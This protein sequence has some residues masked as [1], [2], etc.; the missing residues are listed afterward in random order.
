MIFASLQVVGSHLEHHV[1][2]ARFIAPAKELA[3]AGTY[4][5]GTCTEAIFDLWHWPVKRIKS[6]G[7]AVCIPSDGIPMAS[8]VSEA[9]ASLYR[10]KKAGRNRS[11]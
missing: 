3:D 9:D 5:E 6:L 11:A 7:V 4:D 1:K 10:A 2:G 8:L